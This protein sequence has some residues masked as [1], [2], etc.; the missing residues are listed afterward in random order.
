MDPRFA[1]GN[2]RPRPDYTPR[3][4]ACPH[5]GAPLEIKDER[6]LLVVCGSCGSHLQADA[7][8]STTDLKVLTQEAEA[9]QHTFVL[10][11]GDIFIHDKVRF[12]VIGRLAT[13]DAD[14]DWHS[15]STLQYLLFHPRR[16]S[17]WL[18]SYE[19]NWDLT[20]TCRALPDGDPAFLNKGEALRSHDER[21]WVL[22]EKGTSVIR[23]VDGALPWLASVGDRAEY[24]ELM[25]AEGRG[26]I[27]E[28]ERRQGELEVGRGHWLSSAEVSRAT[29]KDIAA[30]TEPRENVVEVQKSYRW[31]M[32]A[33]LIAL[34]FNGVFLLAV[35]S[36]GSTALSQRFAK[37]DLRGEVMSKPFDVKGDGNVIK[38]SFEAPLNNA[39]MSLDWGLVRGE[40]DVIHIDDQDLDYYHGVEGGESWS[41]GSR[42]KSTYLKVDKA[43]SYRLLLRAVSAQGEAVEASASHV[44]LNIKVKDGVRRPV[45]TLLASVASLLSWIGLMVLYRKWKVGDEEEDD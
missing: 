24:A 16:G 1:P 22:V 27:Y 36:F 3:R 6:S 17:L 9:Q 34:L 41:E 43:G 38:V 13:G 25:S 14:D 15:T 19:G 39:W 10:D 40:D 7:G 42:S 8:V 12:E 35:M 29:R 45:F 30:P 11:I 37:D 18:S 5:C 20:E 26:E 33:A 4:V 44:P 21:K 31:M 23:Y 28:V 2:G 32:L